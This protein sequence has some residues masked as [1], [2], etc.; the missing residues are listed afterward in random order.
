M[1]LYGTAVP[2][3]SPTGAPPHGRMGPGSTDRSPT[4]DPQ[5][6][7]QRMSSDPESSLTRPTHRAGSG[8]GSASPPA[9]D[10]WSVIGGRGFMLDEVP[11]P[12]GAMG[13]GVA[14]GRQLRRGSLEARD[15]PAAPGTGFGALL[16]NVAHP[17]QPT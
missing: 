1:R 3:V 17:E 11:G 6:Q 7:L 13:G 9:E 16:R 2:R 10:D 8:W 12:M 15:Q 14:F 4:L 5:Q